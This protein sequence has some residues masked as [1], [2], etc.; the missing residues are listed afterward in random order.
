MNGKGMRPRL[1]Y[2]HDKYTKNYDRIFK[3]NEQT[4]ITANNDKHVKKQLIGKPT[5][6]SEPYIFP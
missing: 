6:W 5:V 1:G 2:N 4:K 3:P